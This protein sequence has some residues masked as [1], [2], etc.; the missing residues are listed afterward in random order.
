MNDKIIVDGAGLQQ[1]SSQLASNSE[2]MYSLYTNDIVSVLNSCENELK[3][4]GLDYSVVSESFKK[5][6]SSLNS[7]INE[8]VDVLNNT[9]IP[10]YESTGQ[11]IS[12]MFNSDFANQMSANINE[13]LKD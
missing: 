12:K 11:T 7:Q 6:F 9:I 10:G 13:M 2:K 3:V 1:V 8:L 5:V 4:S